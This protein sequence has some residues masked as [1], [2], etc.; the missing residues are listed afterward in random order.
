MPVPSTLPPRR[1][2]P[3]TLHQLDATRIG[4]LSLA[5]SLA[6]LVGA[7]F[8]YLAGHYVMR[9]FLP[10]HRHD[11]RLA[12]VTAGVCIQAACPVRSGGGSALLP[13]LDRAPVERCSL[14]ASS[15]PPQCRQVVRRAR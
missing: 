9:R 5:A 1:R 15:H 11:E 10:A 6:G 12:V 2:R 14:V 8:Y 3:S 7:K 4:T 13:R